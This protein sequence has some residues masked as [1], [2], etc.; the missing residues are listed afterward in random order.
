MSY[1][2][3]VCPS[4]PDQCTV[5]DPLSPYWYKWV[6]KP[7]GTICEHNW[8]HHLSAIKIVNVFSG[9]DFVPVMHCFVLVARWPPNH[10]DSCLCCS[11]PY[12]HQ[13]S[14]STAIHVRKGII[15]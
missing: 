5:A 10:Q 11:V 6:F 4:A 15:S 3:A 12:G 13:Q 8:R 2:F 14:P 9:I 7:A 1:F